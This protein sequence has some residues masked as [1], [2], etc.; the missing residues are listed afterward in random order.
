MPPSPEHDPRFRPLEDESDA[1]TLPSAPGRALRARGTADVVG[2][3]QRQ[4]TRLER[5][6]GQ[7]QAL[8]ELEQAQRQAR[9]AELHP[10]QQ[11]WRRLQRALVLGLEPWLDDKAL[12]ERQ[13]AL[14]RERLCQWARELADAGDAG[15]RE[16]HDRH[17]PLDW[18][19]RRRADAVALRRELEAQLGER[20]D[21]GPEPPT[22]EQVWAAAQARYREAQA[23]QRERREARR[24]RR[25]S[26]RQPVESASAGLSDADQAL[27]R[28]YRQLASQLHPDR[29]TGEADRQW[30]TARM[31]EA[32]TAYEKRDLMALWRLQAEVMPASGGAPA[33]GSDGAAILLL[34][35]QQ[36]A[37]L[38][39]RRAARQEELARLF[40]LPPGQV[41]KPATLEADLAARRRAL[42]AA[43]GTLK[44][45]LRRLDDP[46][47]MR[48]WLRTSGG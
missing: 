31:G 39:R 9:A 19:S 22:T 6:R 47:A 33:Q 3:C 26:P 11:E 29:A 36:V 40:A 32:N 48:R 42:E 1:A 2:E 46:V 45:D 28:L 30:R 15:M 20:L 25:Q 13:R 38:E 44:A 7:L 23:G 17:S 18:A 12:S 27:R 34:L 35:R 24:S 43:I 8:D 41:A 10:L 21:L 14:A 5:L 4:M 37:A 16:L